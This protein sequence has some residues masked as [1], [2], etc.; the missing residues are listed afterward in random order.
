MKEDAIGPEQ[1]VYDVPVSQ[2]NKAKDQFPPKEDMWTT[3][4]SG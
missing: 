3:R 1:V 4:A 2:A